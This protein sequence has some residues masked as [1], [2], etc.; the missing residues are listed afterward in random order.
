M[1]FIGNAI[2]SVL[3]GI[4]GAKQSAKGAQQAAQTQASAADRA[5]AEQRE[6]RLTN[7][8][9]QDPFVKAGT[10]ALA[11]QMGLIGL[12]GTAGQQDAISALLTSPEYTTSVRQGEESI[13]Q[14]ASATGGLRGGN[15]QNSLANFRSDL[16]GGLINLARPERR[17]RRRQRR[18]GVCRSDR[19]FASTAGSCARWR[20]DRQ[21]QRRH[22]QPKQ[23]GAARRHCNRC[24]I[25]TAQGSCAVER[26]RV[27]NH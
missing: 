17:G 20:T 11:A 19:R 14:N 9:R 3:G 8:Q 16:V 18:L 15:T 2:G 1:S 12:N 25:R 5:I 21:G 23:Y 10:S 13:L 6:A 7:E 27:L 4:T 22:D 26:D 24:L